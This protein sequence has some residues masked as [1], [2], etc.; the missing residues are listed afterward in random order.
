[1]KTGDWVLDVGCGTGAQ[2]LEYA[3]QGTIATGIDLDPGMIEL[4]QRGKK[5]SG[6]DV[7][8][9]VADA[10]DL[11]FGDNLFDYVSISLALHAIG[12]TARDEVV[13]EMKRVVKKEGALIFIDFQVP[14][15][16]NAV[17]YLIRAVELIVGGEHSRN[18]RDFMAQGGLDVL[19]DRKQL[20]IEKRGH[21]KA[22]TIA[23]IKTRNDRQRGF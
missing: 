22:G 17:G 11:P 21:L 1:M 15:P 10:S 4:A 18:S 19:L 13:S 16:G 12:S 2:V 14:M 6:L 23:L 5:K 7:L 3:K 9:R 20:S 8:F